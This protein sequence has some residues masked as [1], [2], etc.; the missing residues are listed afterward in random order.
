MSKNWNDAL[1]S[2]RSALEILDITGAP[3]DIG[4]HMDLAIVRLEEAIAATTQDKSPDTRLLSSAC[5]ASK[6]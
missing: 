1:A 5:F 6:H 4:A 2:M 3:M